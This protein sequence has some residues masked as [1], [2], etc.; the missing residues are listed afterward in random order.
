MITVK[1]IILLFPH[2]VAGTRAIRCITK[3]EQ[4]A[5]NQ[6]YPAS[7]LALQ[8]QGPVR[9]QRANALIH[10]DKEADESQAP[11]PLDR[12]RILSKFV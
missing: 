2:F 8:N 3:V 5:G 4:A 1:R 7:V 11:K 12:V 9:K 6:K 10:G